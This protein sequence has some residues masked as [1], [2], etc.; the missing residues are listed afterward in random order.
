ML[1]NLLLILWNLT[2][3]VTII[4][5]V[6]KQDCML[7]MSQ[8]LNQICVI[9]K[10]SLFVALTVLPVE[11]CFANSVLVIHDVYALS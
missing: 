9:N 5:Q 2:P 6:L 8:Y 11:F 10:I 4:S 3:K 7:T 1:T